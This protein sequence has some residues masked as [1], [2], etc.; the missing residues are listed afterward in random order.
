MTIGIE[1]LVQ[2]LTDQGY[3][4]SILK[5]TVGVEYAMIS[6]FEIPSGNFARRIIDLAIPAPTD[7]PRS[8]GPSIHIKANHILAPIGN[9]IPNVRNVV[10]SNLGA[11]WQYWSCRF[12]VRPINPTSELLSQINEYFDRN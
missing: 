1:R 11:D 4:V 3:L 7:Y 9:N 10:K 12:T 2:D 5:D 6:E 8:V